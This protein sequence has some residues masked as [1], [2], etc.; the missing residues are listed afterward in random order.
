M[1][2]QDSNDGLHH[3][4]NR[5]LAVGQSIHT[6]TVNPLQRQPQNTPYPHDLVGSLQDPPPIQSII[7]RETLHATQQ[8]TNYTE[9]GLPMDMSHGRPSLGQTLMHGHERLLA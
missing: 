5:G 6:P 8:Y 2:K 7:H 4:V 1:P 9:H 3:K